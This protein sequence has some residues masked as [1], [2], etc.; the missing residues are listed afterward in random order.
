MTGVNRTGPAPALRNRPGVRSAVVRTGFSRSSNIESPYRSFK[1]TDQ[2]GSLGP[3]ATFGWLGVWPRH[4]SAGTTSAIA[5]NRLVLVMGGNLLGMGTARIRQGRF[6]RPL[7]ASHG[8]QDD[9]HQPQG[10][11]D[12]SDA[13]G[14]GVV[15]VDQ[16]MRPFLDAAP[17]IAR[18]T[19]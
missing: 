4:A 10:R 8:R 6:D 18:L 13:E 1:M 2:S 7:P 16:V 9:R 3:G 17:L 5:A 15:G 12:P 19:W 14:I 11:H